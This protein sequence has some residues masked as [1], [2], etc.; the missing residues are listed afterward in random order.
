MGQEACEADKN[1][2]QTVYRC[3]AVHYIIKGHGFFN[4][5]FLGPG[6]GFVCR[7][8]ETVTY[9]PDPNTPWE[10]FWIR[11]TGDDINCFFELIPA[12]RN[13]VFYH[14]LDTELY[15]LYQF[16]K[17]MS[18]PKYESLKSTVFPVLA[19]KLHQPDNIEPQTTA[20]IY[21]AQV[22]TIIETH[23]FEPLRISEIAKQLH[24]NRC[25]LRNVFVECE[26]ISPCEFRQKMRMEYAAK[27]LIE[28]SHSIKI[29]SHSVGY[30]TQMDFSRA[31]H[32][33]FHISP[34]E[35][36]K[37]HTGQNETP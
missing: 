15:G 27:L 29:I 10:Y 37:Q 17:T 4:G 18:H 25:H 9:F 28:T 3:D 6:M 30:K 35:Y 23:L 20:K 34:T 21:T 5:L 12:D 14:N 36:R 7:A 33:K 16:M 31:F 1:P 24:L 19:Q 2:V 26:G 32:K 8:G 11:M 13:G 22:K